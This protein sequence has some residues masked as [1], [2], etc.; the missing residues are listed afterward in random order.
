MLPGL[1]F[2]TQEV[3]P[4]LPP[5]LPPLLTL[6]Q[7]GC[8][9]TPQCHFITYS[10]CV[11]EREKMEILFGMICRVLLSMRGRGMR[12]QQHQD[13]NGEPSATLDL[14]TTYVNRCPS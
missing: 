14:K 12:L 4:P 13:E 11:C 2:E 5:P 1:C 9:K 10:V 3:P 6:T 7:S 8:L